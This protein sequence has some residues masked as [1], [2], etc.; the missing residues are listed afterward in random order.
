MTIASTKRHAG[1]M[2]A[3]ELAAVER[4]LEVFLE[5]LT[6]FMGRRD[7]RQAYAWDGD[8]RAADPIHPRWYTRAGEADLNEKLLAPPVALRLRTIARE[9]PPRARPR[10]S[11]AARRGSPSSAAGTRRARRPSGWRAAARS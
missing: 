11:C 6:G 4:R 3:S 10:P 9:L 5:G 2:R 8:R 7:R 1:R